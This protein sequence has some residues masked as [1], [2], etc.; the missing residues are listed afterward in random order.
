M[1]KALRMKY[2]ISHSLPVVFPLILLLFNAC[3]PEYKVE[4]IVKFA[5]DASVTAALKAA[6]EAQL[7]ERLRAGE[8][9]DFTL[10]VTGSGFRIETMHTNQP[11]AAMA[12]LMGY[13]GSAALGIYDVFPVDDPALQPV[14]DS[15]PWPDYAVPT[16]DSMRFNRGQV[17]STTNIAR[18]QTLREELRAA[19][20]SA[21]PVRYFWST[22]NRTNNAGR[23]P[24]RS[25]DLLAVRTSG[26]SGGPRIGN[27]AVAETAVSSTRDGQIAVMVDFT[28]EAAAIWSEMTAEAAADNQRQ[29]AIV[30]NQEV[31][32]S[33][34]VR[35]A[36]TTGKTMI[37][38]NFSVEIADALAKQLKWGPLPVALD[39][40]SQQV[41]E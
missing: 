40:V 10:E 6:T 24:A 30:V 15:F 29:V 25:F 36:I 18:M 19:T 32:S 5:E 41:V 37:T 4:T 1:R 21:L 14:L 33:P 31:V 13:F 7:T 2:F 35:E 27:A 8:G 22:P 12:G 26:Q 34:S 23:G 16:P 17:V 39:L 9:E 28:P 3:K 20:P 11:I 38:G